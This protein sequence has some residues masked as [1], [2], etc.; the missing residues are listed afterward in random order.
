MHFSPHQLQEIIDFVNKNSNVFKYDPNFKDKCTE[1]SKP[2]Q[3]PLDL[4]SKLTEPKADN[5][6]KQRHYQI[7]SIQHLYDTLNSHVF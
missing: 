4:F 7:Q 2:D 6:K 1:S 5:L 3:K